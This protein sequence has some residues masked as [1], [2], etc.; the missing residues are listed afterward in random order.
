MTK[1]LN[2][3]AFVA[4]FG[5]LGALSGAAQ[6]VTI[7]G[8]S[9]PSWDPNTS[10]LNCN[11]SSGPPVCSFNPTAPT[12]YTLGNQLTLTASCTNNPSYVW[13]ATVGALGTGSCASAAT[14][15]DKQTTTPTTVNYH[16]VASNGQ[17]STMLDASVNW[18]VGTGPPSGCVIAPAPQGLSNSATPQAISPMTVSCSAGAPL[19]TFAWTTGGGAGCNPNFVGSTTATQTDTLPGNTGTSGASCGYT[20]T[21]G[22]GSGTATPTATVTVAGTGGGTNISCQP[23]GSNPANVTTDLTK[24]LVQVLD[25]NQAAINGTS[26]MKTGVAWVGILTVPTS[27]ITVPSTANGR[28]VEADWGGSMENVWMTVASTPCTWGASATTL[29]TTFG[30]DGGWGNVSVGGTGIS[31]TPGQTYYINVQSWNPTKNKTQCATPATCN[32]TVQWYKPS[33]T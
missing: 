24:T 4:V 18:I 11:G 6:G 9:S 23:G 22:N 26:A 14:C 15:T 29:A 1:S 31:L 12:Q 3:L 8:C 21:V 27:G 10:T 20:A 25:W 32:I 17:G 16:L 13:T 2:A 19:T 7:A 5:L 33:G 30:A 28:I